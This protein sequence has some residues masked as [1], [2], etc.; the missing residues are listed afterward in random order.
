MSMD[1]NNLNHLIKAQFD[2]AAPDVSSIADAHLDR[3]TQAFT[4]IAIQTRDL[5]RSNSLFSHRSFKVAA[6]AFALMVATTS[7]ALAGV[8]PQPAQDAL[9]SAAHVAGVTLPHSSKAGKKVHHNPTAA[10]AIAKPHAIDNDATEAVENDATKSEAIESDATDTDATEAAK[11]PKAHKANHGG[12]VSQVAHNK[13][14]TGR[15]HGQAV[16]AAA[17]TNGAAHRTAQH[18]ATQGKSMAARTHRGSVAHQAT[19]SM[20]PSHPARPVQSSASHPAHPVH[21]THHK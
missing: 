19:P 3:M 12:T 9:A 2:A 14:T 20:H 21:P 5:S 13:T 16:S 1:D 11:A 18:H 17:R 6:G 10:A 4:P 8:M 7:M 15:A